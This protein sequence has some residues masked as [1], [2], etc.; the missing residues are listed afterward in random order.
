MGERC[1]MILSRPV[2]LLHY[3]IN[4]VKNKMKAVV[5]FY[6]IDEIVSNYWLYNLTN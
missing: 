5:S 3:P 2:P 1:K 4:C 6:K